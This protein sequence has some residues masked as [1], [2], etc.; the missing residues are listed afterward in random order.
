MV[1]CGG[2]PQGG[3][4]PRS[5]GIAWRVADSLS[6]RQLLNFSLTEQTPDHSSVS[7]TRRLFALETRKAEFRWFVE[8]LGK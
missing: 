5:R 4:R 8:M 3:K 2:H 1:E 6:L 7:R